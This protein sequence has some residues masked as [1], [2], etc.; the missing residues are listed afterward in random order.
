LF[1]LLPPVAFSFF[2]VG[3]VL[4][5]G[6]GNVFLYS[7][8]IADS[9]TSVSEPWQLLSPMVS[10]PGLNSQFGA[11]LALS[12]SSMDVVVGGQMHSARTQQHVT[13]TIGPMPCSRC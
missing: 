12:D 2:S 10:A 11:A 3:A 9:V 7:R 4:N 13:C 1:H 5:L 6:N 8:N